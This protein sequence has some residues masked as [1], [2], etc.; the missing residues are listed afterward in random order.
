MNAI[1]NDQLNAAKEAMIGWLAHPAELGKAPAKIE[2]AG[3][4]DL[5][6]LH[7]YIF[8]YK[9]SALGKWLLG[10]CGGYEENELENCGH[11]FSEREE[12]HEETAVEQATALVEYVRE[13]YM[14]RAKEAEERK[15]HAGNF[16][17]YVLLSEAKWDKEALLRDL[18]ETWGIEDEEPEE[19]DENDEDERD[20]AFVISYQGAM[21]AI[22]LMPGPIPDGEAEYA[23][24]KNFMWKDG[25]DTVKQHKAH[26]LVAQ[27]GRDLPPTESGEMLVK[28]VVSACKQEGVLGIYTGDVVLEPRYYLQF[29]EALGSD[30]FPITNLV[31]VGL[32]GNEKGLCGYTAGMRNF[33]YDEMEVLNS[34]AEPMELLDF[35]TSI[36]NYVITEEVILQDGET[37]GFTA[38]Q[39]CAITKSQ[40]VAVEGDSLKIEY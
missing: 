5:H 38:E 34:S 33:G 17:N 28:A 39:K 18:K 4:F 14:D 35:L 26:I 31:W 24:A 7:Y 36:A 29:A 30:E 8:K 25:K 27:L 15:E 37:I 12:Y 10:V 16:I 9:K 32:H 6:E 40:G 20:D 21:L 23:A 11:V 22:S 3:E 13:Y 2:C 19:D 1:N